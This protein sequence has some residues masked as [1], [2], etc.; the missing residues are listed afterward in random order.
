VIDEIFRRIV[1]WFAPILC[2]TMEEAWTMR[3]GMDASVH[4]NDFFPAPQE[5]ANADLVRKWSRIRELRRLVTG[6]LELARAD[7]L[8]GSSLEAAP[9]LGVSDANDKALFESIDLAEIA[10]TST[11]SVELVS[12]LDGF[13]TLPDVKGA[14]AKY[15][16]AQ[17][18]K[19]A[20]CWR[21]LEETRP[22]TLLCNRC[23]DAIGGLEP[24]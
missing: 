19:C 14:G 16:K 23:T 18:L 20:R 22:D 4:L 2:F 8:I 3:F 5:W 6:V 15:A 10:I 1:T 9:V 13:Y 17:G 12:G 21:V 11:A 24:P 7:K